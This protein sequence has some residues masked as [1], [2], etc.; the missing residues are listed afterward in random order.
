MTTLS[1]S[2]FAAK[3]TQ[4]PGTTVIDQSSISKNNL[5]SYINECCKFVAQTFTAGMTG[6][7]AG[8]T[9]DVKSIPNSK[10]HLH[11]AIRTVTTSGMPSPTIL[12]ETTLNSGSSPISQFI[13]FPQ[14]IHFIAGDQYAIVVNYENAPPAGK[15]QGQGIWLGATRDTYSG[16][17]LY[18]SISDGISWV[19]MEGEDLH[20]QTYVNYDLPK[21]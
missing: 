12:G 18:T 17:N 1:C 11:V 21:E 8:I 15:G 4:E 3:P 16:G 20:F 14:S 7:L 6:T 13:S 9:I 19:Q 2:I 5:A 10:F